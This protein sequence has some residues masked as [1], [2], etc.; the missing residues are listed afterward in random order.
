MNN[1]IQIE[2]GN[3]SVERSELLI[4]QLSEIG[5]AGFEENENQLKAFIPEQDFDKVLFHGCIEPFQIT[6]TETLI[7]EVNWNRVWESNFDPVIVDD[8]V[9]IRADFHEPIKGVSF[10]II[11]T[12][13]MSF[14][15]GHHATTYMMIEQMRGLNFTGK[16]VF[17]F[18]TGTGVLAILAEKL[19][20]DKVI[21]ADND[22]WSIENAKENF[23][24]NNCT[25][26]DLQFLDSANIDGQ[27]DFIL[28]NINRNV[29]LD[30]LSY[31]KQHLSQQGVLLLS[32]IL[33][34]DEPAIL[35]KS[36]VCGIKLNFKS[37]RHNWLF[38]SLSHREIKY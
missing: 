24:K 32:G 7:P 17:D 4:A 8:F 20:A 31:F 14:G 27:F 33:P 5:F 12:P 16:S 28:A 18:G 6:F 3:I 15:T 19:G 29:I 37:Q 11:I 1:Y 38:L 26:I 9:T 21:A 2:F 34:E 13:K 22:Q 23:A 10:E 35:E 25:A 30:N 36:Q